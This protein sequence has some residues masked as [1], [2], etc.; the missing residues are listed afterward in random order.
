MARRPHHD[1][2]PRSGARPSS[3]R[4]ARVRPARAA[5][6]VHRRDRPAGGDLAAVP[7]PP[8]RL[9]EGALHAPRAPRGR[10]GGGG[11][12]GGGGRGGGGKRGMQST[13]PGWWGELQ[14]YARRPGRGGREASA[15]YGGQLPTGP[16]PTGE[17]GGRGATRRGGTRAPQ[18]GC[19][20]RWG[21]RPPAGGAEE[22]RGPRRVGRLDDYVETVSGC[23]TSARRGSSPRG[24]C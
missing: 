20:G 9:E 24:C 8:L 16:A 2:R 13:G 21:R 11:G 7:L 5:R 6:R 1:R 14:A 17:G 18:G 23:P 3:R 22:I 10:G 12:G 4:R 15:G 19:K